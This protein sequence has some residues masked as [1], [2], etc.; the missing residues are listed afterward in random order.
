MQ[1]SDA[2][3]AQHSCISENGSTFVSDQLPP[4]PE[5]D[6]LS[7][8]TQSAVGEA[9]LLRGAL[10]G[11]GLLI[12]GRGRY[13][14]RP[15]EY[16]LIRSR[17]GAR[18]ELRFTQEEQPVFFSEDSSF[19][20]DPSLLPRLA[21]TIRGQAG[22]GPAFNGNEVAQACFVP[23]LLRRFV[24]GEKTHCFAPRPPEVIANRA[25]ELRAR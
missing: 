13:H 5:L 16:S 12:V 21:F 8:A 9:S 10:A 15:S 24:H 25:V 6:Q 14:D 3:T 22:A 11:S 18:L 2:A 20:A 17:D 7:T 4:V 19:A 1:C 23:D